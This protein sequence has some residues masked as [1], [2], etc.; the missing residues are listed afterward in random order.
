MSPEKPSVLITGA[1]GFVGSRLCRTFLENGFEVI[2]GV[3][4]T[5]SLAQLEGL[6]ITYRYGDVCMPETLPGMVTGVDYIVHN[7]G[8][9]KVKRN[10]RFFEVNEGGTR[11]LFD[12]IAR[13][14][15]GVRKVIYVSSLAAAGPSKPGAPR[16]ESDPPIPLTAYARS[17][18]A[19]ETA[20]L[21]FSDRFSVV[22][23]RPS[24]VYG[25]GDRE[26]FAFFL[27][28]SL[29]VKPLIGKTG[30]KIQLVHVDDLCR[31]IY[32]AVTTSTPSEAVYFIAEDRSYTMKEL[33]RIIRQV[34]GK[35][36]VPLYI[37]AAPF[38]VI[39]AFSQRILKLFNVT[40][41]LT[42]EKAD[43]LLGS[44]E[45]S[46]ARARDELG[47]QSSIAFEEGARQ[48]FEWYKKEGWL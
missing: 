45:V 12:A 33:I 6:D 1:N 30:R 46:T 27:A 3:R 7:A 22:A 18:L 37:P 9:V 42:P 24:G 26:N 31:G 47:F 41:M 11:A 10:E 32:L 25:P 16:Q 14:N 36:A 19:G 44:W 5:A 17:K 23:V 13:H 43:E 35:A 21:S 38:K 48:T 29:R 4:K 28:L 2:A 8:V 15:P 40:P 20:A 39:A 34:V